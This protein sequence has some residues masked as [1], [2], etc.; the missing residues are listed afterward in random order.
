MNLLLGDVI[1][2]AVTRV[3]NRPAV[4]H[5][6]RTLTYPEVA[7]RAEHIATV[8]AKRG[9]TRGSRVVW[10]GDTQVDAVP[11][12][13]GLALLGAVF[14]PINPAFGLSEGRPVIDRADPALVLVDDAHEGELTLA[15]V[16]ATRGPA[17]VDLPEV[18]E[19]DPHII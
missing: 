10:W 3:G 16:L 17:V 7:E 12:F 11:L 6:D 9:I 8:L 13:F 2:N 15:E 19:R 4:T 1:P 14:V 18:D 5:R